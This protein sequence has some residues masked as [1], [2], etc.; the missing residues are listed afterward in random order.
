[1]LSSKPDKDSGGR[2]DLT[3]DFRKYIYLFVKLTSV[4]FLTLV[5]VSTMLRRSH[6]IWKDNMWSKTPKAL[7]TRDVT[8]VLF[9]EHWREQGIECP[10][11]QLLDYNHVPCKMP[12]NGLAGAEVVRCLYNESISYK[13]KQSCVSCMEAIKD[14]CILFLAS[15][16]KI[17]T[18]VV[19][20]LLQY[21]TNIY[22]LSESSF[23]ILLRTNVEV[24][25]SSFSLIFS[26]EYS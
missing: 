17:S 22:G 20:S 4:F 5:I 16:R 15:K 3:C 25:S 6:R 2:N 12:W 13:V 18:S 7:V 10:C 8:K 24:S 11:G 21:R 9:I 14:L 1:M 23:N 19:N 26:L